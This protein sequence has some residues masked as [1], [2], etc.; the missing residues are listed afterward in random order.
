MASGPGVTAVKGALPRA[1]GIAIVAIW[2]EAVLSL[3]WLVWRRRG[4]AANA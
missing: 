1:Y 3:I 2:I 4:R